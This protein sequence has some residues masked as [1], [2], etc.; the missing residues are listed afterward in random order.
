MQVPSA[1]L[2]SFLSWKTLGSTSCLSPS[3]L[4]NGYHLPSPVRSWSLAQ[5]MAFE[6]PCRVS[7]APVSKTVI[8]KLWCES[9]CRL[10]VVHLL[11]W[12]FKAWD[13]DICMFN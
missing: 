3:G 13:E 1:L 7:S 8:S 9:E 12:K 4:W 10:P 5:L 2:N 6:V 11:I